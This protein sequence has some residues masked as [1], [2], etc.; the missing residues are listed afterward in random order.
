MK[1]NRRPK[2][3]LI[4]LLAFSLLL[5]G[6]LLFWAYSQ[7]RAYNFGEWEA[8]KGVAPRAIETRVLS[9]Q[10][11]AAEKARTIV[12]SQSAAV[13][14]DPKKPADYLGERTQRV[15]KESRAKDF[16]SARGK[17][18]A[19]QTAPKKKLPSHLNRLEKLGLS[20]G[21][22]PSIAEPK[23]REGAHEVGDGG[24]GELRKGSMDM[25]ESHVAVGAETLLN[26]D[27][28]IYASFFNRL[29]E[30]VAPRWEPLIQMALD[31]K[32]KVSPGLYRTVVVTYLDTEGEVKDV[33][34]TKSSGFGPF[35]EAATTSIWQ[36]LR[37]KNPPHG[38]REKDGSYR[39]QLAF[40]VNYGGGGSI[41]MNYEPD[42]RYHNPTY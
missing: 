42:P 11:F 23:E 4:A 22:G 18:G 13:V 30:E 24:E 1:K 6:L 5:H 15:E 19:A 21:L 9:P 39:V 33:K 34:V 28:Y 29:K 36:L 40:V 26:T 32:R 25:L 3:A 16:G 27:E 17:K 7:M 14:N 38:L 12:Q 2:N 41:R 35:D 20:H 10:E 31:A 37:I 8:D